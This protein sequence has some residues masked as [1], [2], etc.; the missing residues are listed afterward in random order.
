ML[1]LAQSRVQRSW[2][3]G[4]PGEPQLGGRAPRQGSLGGCHSLGARVVDLHPGPRGR[5]GLNKPRPGPIKRDELTRRLVN[6]LGVH[7]GGAQ[8]HP[9][10]HV[11]SDFPRA[12]RSWAGGRRTPPA[13]R[14]APCT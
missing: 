10:G 12:G 14:S 13:G 11:D 5:R 6:E 7:P 9:A 4:K 2:E 8:G 3:R 1:L